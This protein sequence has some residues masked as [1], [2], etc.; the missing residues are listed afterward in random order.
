MSRQEVGALYHKNGDPTTINS[1]EC[2][3]CVDLKT[4]TN[5][6]AGKVR[7]M[8]KVDATVVTFGDV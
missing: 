2:G 8:Y 7:A 3:T 6:Q 5:I 4:Q 1:A